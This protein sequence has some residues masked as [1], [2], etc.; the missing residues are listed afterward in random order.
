MIITT[1]SAVWDDNGVRYI[2]DENLGS[3][4]FGAVYK[5]HREDDGTVVAIKT[6]LKPIYLFNVKQT[7]LN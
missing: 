3:G 6:L 7:N 2:L 5:A 4:G 1:G